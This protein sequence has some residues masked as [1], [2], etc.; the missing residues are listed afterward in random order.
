MLAYALQ[1]LA[2]LRARRT[3]AIHVLPGRGVRGGRPARSQELPRVGAVSRFT[4]WRK[5]S[6]ND[7]EVGAVHR[8]V[9]ARF[10]HLLD[11]AGQQRVDAA[12]SRA[13][14]GH[15]RTGGTAVGDASPPLSQASQA[16]AKFTAGRRSY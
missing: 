6:W 15:F 8:R 5:R 9:K 14:V 4:G 13:A 16:I 1:I 12:T 10:W 2:R 7:A 11:E 3:A